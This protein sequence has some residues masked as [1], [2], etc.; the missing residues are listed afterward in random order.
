MAATLF[1][2]A[3]FPRLSTRTWKEGTPTSKSPRTLAP[4][5]R[6]AGGALVYLPSTTPD[7]PTLSQIAP[8]ISLMGGLGVPPPPQVSD[9]RYFD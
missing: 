7:G 6:A 4:Q 9:T 8:P 1:P 3:Q 2:L 5:I